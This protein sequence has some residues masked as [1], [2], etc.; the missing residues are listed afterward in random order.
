MISPIGPVRNANTPPRIPAAPPAAVNAAA[1]P[2]TTGSSAPIDD[3]SVPSTIS[4]GPI[5]AA[6]P[7]IPITTI[8]V[9]GL[10]S[11]NRPIN[12]LTQSTTGCSAAIT[13]PSTGSS[14]FPNCCP[15]TCTCTAACC[16]ENP[17]AFT[18]CVCAANAAWL[19]PAA[20]P[21]ASRLL[22]NVSACGPAS[23]SAS[24]CPSIE[25]M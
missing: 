17:T 9:A 23:A 24:V 4:T 18:P 2:P 15:H 14:A 3:T 22:P 12:W 25:P 19:A 6:S 1:I 7:A 16:I 5:A 10:A 13:C 11:V 21:I 8:C 20:F